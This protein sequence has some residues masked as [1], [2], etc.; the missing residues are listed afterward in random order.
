MKSKFRFLSLLSRLGKGKD[1][2]GPRL[3]ARLLRDED[4]SYLV[5]MTL[6]IP[7]VIGVCG[8]AGEASLLLY[9]KRTLQSAA[10]GLRPI[11]RR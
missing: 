1:A 11:A 5:Y 3:L 4:G 7:V 6:L 2:S 8:L 9:N 10:R